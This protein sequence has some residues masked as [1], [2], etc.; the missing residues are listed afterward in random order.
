M[1]ASRHPLNIGRLRSAFG[2][3]EYKIKQYQL[4][5]FFPC[6][7]VH[8]TKELIREMTGFVR[9]S[10]YISSA[11][12]NTHTYPLGGRIDLAAAPA[13]GPRGPYE[14]TALLPEAPDGEPQY[15][16]RS[17]AGVERVVTEAEILMLRSAPAAS[18][19]ALEPAE[20]PVSKARTAA[21]AEREAEARSAWKDYIDERDAI[22]RRTAELRAL[23]LKAEADAAEKIMRLAKSVAAK[24]GKSAGKA[25]A[26]PVRPAANAAVPAAKPAAKAE[27]KPAVKGKA[28]PVAAKPAATAK[29]ASK[30]AAS[31]PAIAKPAAPKPAAKA[32]AKA[33]PA[34]KAKAPVKAK[35]PVKA[36]AKSV[37]KTPVKTA[38]KPK[39]K[40][41]KAKPAKAKAR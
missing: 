35:T 34:A 33:K 6:H 15:A 7:P 9:T 17:E 30:P 19:K 14:I 11:M 27:A 21:Q 28:E 18:E 20:E 32:P 29:P 2:S 38:A 13:N 16:I 1:P 12:Q 3:A 10:P 31:K 24:A 22:I 40:T 8:Q 5:G 41:A 37:K 23:R 25:A 36:A 26:K 4:L 39:A